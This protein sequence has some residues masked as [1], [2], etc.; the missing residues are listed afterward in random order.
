MTNETV[1]QA[2]DLTKAAVAANGTKWSENV[3]QVVI[4]LQTVAKTLDSMKEGK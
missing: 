4:F 1:N 2:I 3:A